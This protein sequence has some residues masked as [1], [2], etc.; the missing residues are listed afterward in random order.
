MMKVRILMSLAAGIVMAG[1]AT[2]AGHGISTEVKVLRTDQPQVFEARFLIAEGKF[3]EHTVLARPH[4]RFE[5]GN[6]AVMEVGNDERLIRAQIYATKN[7]DESPAFVY[8]V[9]IDEN[10]KR[11]YYDSKVVYV[12]EPTEN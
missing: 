3:E 7:D 12:S 5:R 2:F 11:K 9:T 1:C 4:I 6:R 8:R 10:G